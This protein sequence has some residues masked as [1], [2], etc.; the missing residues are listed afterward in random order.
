MGFTV[1]AFDRA[2]YGAVAES[3]FDDYI[4]K[5][6]RGSLGDAEVTHKQFVQNMKTLF[7]GVGELKFGEAVKNFFSGCAG[8]LVRLF[9]SD[10]KL[11]LQFSQKWLQAR[12]CKHEQVKHAVDSAEFTGCSSQLLHDIDE[13]IGSYGRFTVKQ[14]D[15]KKERILPRW[16]KFFFLDYRET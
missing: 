15:G 14:H 8:F 9:T 5:K 13:V 4:A 1:S 2:K 6:N 10:K 11:G 7:L 12:G 16:K 3:Q